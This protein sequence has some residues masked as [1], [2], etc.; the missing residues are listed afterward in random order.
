M[1]HSLGGEVEVGDEVFF[2]HGVGR[3]TVVHRGVP[4]AA[5]CGVADA[6]GGCSSV[7]AV[8][9]GADRGAVV[10]D[11]SGPGDSGAGFYLTGPFRLEGVDRPNM[12]PLTSGDCR[13]VVKPRTENGLGLHW[14]DGIAG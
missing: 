1:L 3:V 6:H 13:E 11:G 7:A 5:C 14:E 9:N 2:A 10:V 8:V 12:L 4:C